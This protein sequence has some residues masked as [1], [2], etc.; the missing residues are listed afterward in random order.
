MTASR[1]TGTPVSE[2]TAAGALY[3][4]DNAVLRPG[5]TASA[6]PEQVA[7][8]FAAVADDRAGLASN[9]RAQGREQEAAIVEVA[10]LIAAD[11]ILVNPAV[12]AVQAGTDAAAAVTA[13]A[14]AQAAILAG[15]D[16]PELSERSGDVRQIAQ[17][18]LERLAGGTPEPPNEDF[19]LVRREVAAADLIELA[20]SGLAGAVSIAGGAS[21][22][23]AIV[24]RGLGLPM[25]TGIDASVLASTQGCPALL[26][27]GAGVLTL[28]PTAVELAGARPMPSAAGQPRAAAGHAWTID[29][30]KITILCNVASAA[31]TRRGLAEGAAGV[32]LLRT[33]IPFVAAADWPTTMQHEQQ[34]APILSLLAG[35]PATV[36]LLDFS[37]DKIP[38]FLP[39]GRS[40]LAE[41][42]GHPTALADQ[43]RVVMQAGRDT[44]LAILIPMVSTLAEV[45]TVRSV[46][47]RVAAELAVYAPPIGIMVEL[48]Q[49]AATAEM[50]AAHVDFFSIGTN[51]L[52][53]Q[54]LNLSRLDPTAGPGFAADPRVLELIGHVTEAAAAADISISVCGDAAADRRVLP[55]LIGL[56]V[57][58]VSVPAAKV[59]QVHDWLSN[60][61]VGVCTALAAKAAAALSA[62]ENWELVDR[63]GL[64]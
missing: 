30:H 8:A 19:I 48:A 43:L 40:G 36:R 4:A 20:D 10:A 52:A 11:P 26:D 59:G 37:G 60:L 23:A 51:D 27:G 58:V 33:E 63:A 53:S 29:G 61:D 46:V 56:G 41:L 34:L 14:E 2:G 15:L 1:F 9:L 18:V 31:E 38:A 54:V 24:A 42:L 49:T 28:E 47:E 45:A 50:F 6:S 13:A 12:A 35:R 3:L 17:A 5:P 57:R 16:S 55:L 62:R 25:V 64:S 32:G 39:P 7:A 44:E 22:H 21:S